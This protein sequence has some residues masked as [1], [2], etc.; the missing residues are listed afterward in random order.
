MLGE[1]GFGIP[2]AIVTDGDRTKGRGYLGLARAYRLIGPFS[3]TEF[4]RG[5]LALRQSA[6]AALEQNL[7]ATAWADAIFI[8][9]DTLE[10][11]VVPLLHREMKSAFA[12]LA[13]GASNVTEFSEAHRPCGK[14]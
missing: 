13:R 3:Q 2:H 9:L 5:V 7:L 6:N 11:D 14:R 8:G 10:L 12:D 1:E 4:G